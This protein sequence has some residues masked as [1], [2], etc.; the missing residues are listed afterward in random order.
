MK[1]LKI[2]LCIA[3]V[4]SFSTTTA[5]A[6]GL[7]S[8]NSG[9]EDIEVSSMKDDSPNEEDTEK[10]ESSIY[11]VNKIEGNI[12]Q[13]NLDDESLKISLDEYLANKDKISFE[14]HSFEQTPQKEVQV[15][16]ALSIIETNLKWN[17]SLDYSNKPKKM[18]LH[19]IEASRPGST[20]P[21]TDV[22]NWHLANG[23]TGIGYH[24]YITKDGKVYRGRPENA[25]GAHAKGVNAESIGIAVE[26]KYDV[27]HMPEAQKKSVIELGKYLKNKYKMD[28]ILKHKD[29][30]STDC[31]GK[32]YPFESIK[33]DILKNES[34]DSFVPPMDEEPN[35]RPIVDKTLKVKYQVHGQD[36]AWQNPVYDGQLGGTQGEWRRMEGIK[37]NLQDAPQDLGIMYRTHSEG[38]SGWRNWNSNGELGGTQGQAKR[39]EAIQI[40]LTGKVAKNY[41]IKYRVHVAGKGWLPWVKNGETAGTMGES[42]R[43][44]GI[45]IK[46]ESNNAIGVEYQVQGQDYGWQKSKRDGQLGGTEYQW[47]RMEGLKINLKNA[48]A[49]LGIKYSTH[50]AGDSGWRDWKNNGELSGTVGE[51][52]RMEAIKVELTGNNANQYDVEYRAQGEGYGWQPWVKNGQMAGSMGQSRRMEGIEIR[53]VKK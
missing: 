36:Y 40:N 42:R 48:P 14:Q 46:I 33:N 51:W 3:C 53:I 49:G 2:M 9:K 4:L 21:V 24:F 41:D 7:D 47:R 11:G 30:N 43:I 1:R 28:N 23:W 15:S 32:N 5:L 52:R 16:K 12:A 10:N 31:P 20:I 17:G 27:E 6:T 37:I 50:S 25:V 45:E 13:E 26:G 39:M 18:V 35:T 44:E 8:V 22:H 34:N 19:H 29:V 38:D